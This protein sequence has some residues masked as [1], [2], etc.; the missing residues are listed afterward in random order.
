MAKQIRNYYKTW[1]MKWDNCCYLCN[2]WY[3]SF[4]W[5][6]RQSIAK[7]ISMNIFV[8][9][10]ALLICFLILILYLTTFDMRNWKII[11]RLSGESSP[12]GFKMHPLL[13]KTKYFR[14]RQYDTVWLLSDFFVSALCAREMK[15]ECSYTIC[16]GQTLWHLKLIETK[17][18]EVFL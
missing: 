9:A 18:Y 8:K 10:T 17:T 15:I 6:C 3:S 12:S 16:A 4:F 13:N 7:S 5:L 2:E 1:N 11:I 14:L